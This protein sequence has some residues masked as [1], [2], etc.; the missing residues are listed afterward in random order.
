MVGM[1]LLIVALSGLAPEAEPKTK[2]DWRAPAGCPEAGEVE[3]RLTAI[4]GTGED[5]ID[6][7]GE[8]RETGD[9][10]APYTARFVFRWH[11]EVSERTVD[12][13]DCEALTDAALLLVAAQ[14]D[15]VPEP[16]AELPPE[17]AVPE[18]GPGPATNAG[19]GEVIEAVPLDPVMEL[20]AEPAAIPEEQSERSEPAS[21]PLTGPRLEIGAVM[22]W[23]VVPRAAFGGQIGM[24]WRFNRARV[25]IRGTF[26]GPITVSR[27]FGDLGLR[28]AT[29]F[30]ASGSAH[31]C[32]QPR[33]GRWEFP[34]CAQVEVGGSRARAFGQQT[35]SAGGPWSTI[36]AGTGVTV[37]LQRRWALGLDAELVIPLRGVEYTIENRQLFRPAPVG[38]LLALRLSP[39]L[40]KS[41]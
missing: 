9:P 34:Q 7:S 32:W 26:W 27:N 33:R 13:D 24:R 40:K 30:L 16:P 35:R 5:A 3:R 19:S 21:S 11:G 6:L 36:S 37:H 8:I 20:D 1:S 18:P 12:G 25:G 4:A 22:S 29:L 2:L 10:T 17:G 28:G 41:H 39:A 23:G 31:G 14:A 38:V 15:A